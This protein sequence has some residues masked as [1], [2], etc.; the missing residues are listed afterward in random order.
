MSPAFSK[1]GSKHQTW[2]LTAR[3]AGA[4][5]SRSPWAPS[6]ATPRQ[7]RSAKTT[8]LATKAIA[9]PTPSR[10]PRATANT[11]QNSPSCCQASK[12]RF[13][14]LP[15]PT[16]RWCPGP[17]PS[18]SMSGYPRPRSLS[19]LARAI[20]AGKKNPLNTPRWSQAG[21]TEP[22][23]RRKAKSTNERTRRVNM[24][25]TDIL[26]DMVLVE[27]K[28]TATI[29]APVERVDIADWLLHLPDAEYQRCA[30][31]DHIAA[32][33]TTTD[34][35]R[36]M[37]INVEVIG[38][39]LMVQHY[40]AEVHEPHHCRMVSLSDVQTPAGW[41]KIQVIWDLSVTALDSASCR[42][43]NQVLSYPTAAF[44][45]TLESPGSR[46][47]TPWPTAKPP[48]TTT[49][50]VRQLSMHK[51][52]NGRP[53]PATRFAD[54][55]TLPALGFLPEYLAEHPGDRLDVI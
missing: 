1:S 43:T 35:A 31:P 39:T 15:E 46:S 23:R 32:G 37:S 22:M 21:G 36:P 8:C 10:T 48:V 13:G 9:S 19:L 6:R 25:T 41:T 52:S 53:W 45:E 27:S 17:T 29:H 55:R 50:A 18:S 40:V 30:P 2:S 5:S 34:D 11:F 28:K 16:T 51:V 24:T 12:H 14:S 47:K 49:T 26:T 54:R 38:G 4:R 3:W 33:T 7:T 42:Y 44:L 20:S